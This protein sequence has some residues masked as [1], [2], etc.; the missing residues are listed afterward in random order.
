[1]KQT[2]S[3]LS[4]RVR[5]IGLTLL[6]STLCGTAAAQSAGSEKYNDLITRT[7]G[8]PPYEAMYHML[9]YQ[10]FHPE[11]APIYY[12]LGDVVYSMLPSKDA[13]H[14]YDE[15]AE[16][17][18]KARL[19][20]GNCLHFLEGKVP[21]G[22]AFPT[23]K[24]AG[25]RLEYAD[26][27]KYL[28]AHLDTI[29]RWRAE[30]DTLHSRF[31]RMVDSY[32]SC[33][34]LFLGF[35][36]KYPSEKLAHLCFTLE[37]R[38]NLRQLTRLT[39]QMEQDKE[40]FLKAL[41]ASPVPYYNPQFRSLPIAVYRLDGI[42]SSDFLANDIPVWDYAAWTNSFL[43]VQQRTY[44]TLMKDLVREFTTL[45][46]GI[47]RF[48]QGQSIQLE[49]DRRIPNRMECFDYNSPLAAFIRLE[50]MVAAATMQA[51]DSLTAGEQINDS[52]LSL[53]ITANIEAKQHAAE[54]ENMLRTLKQ[55]ID[56]S[57]AQKYVYFLN[58]TKIVTVERL[59][60]TAEQAFAFQQLLTRQIDEQLQNYANAYPKQFEDVDISD[61][62]AA[63]EAATK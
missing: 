8:L 33:R 52:E 27:E 57:T 10:R 25:S 50:Q 43:D 42:T 34:Q 39:L 11:Q 24:P 58:A 17:L 35:M 32:E 41:E 60:E 21:R 49:P 1:M 29:N 16:L 30:T 26:L 18:Y 23:V 46:N 15:R 7:E 22:E 61:D 54:T 3:I 44:L 5:A 40:L 48:R 9:A 38:D 2:L 51:A 13:L 45:D 55:R 6:L 31:Y 12:R 47:E 59:V 4:T 56:A 62:Q 37:D 20:Y 14:N 36:N 19:F 28:R 63:S 53:R